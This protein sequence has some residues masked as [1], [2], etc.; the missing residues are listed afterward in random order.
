MTE[1]SVRGGVLPSNAVTGKAGYQGD[2]E[3]CVWRWTNGGDVGYMGIG[4][5]RLGQIERYSM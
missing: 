4:G 2:A 1:R 5:A 3:V